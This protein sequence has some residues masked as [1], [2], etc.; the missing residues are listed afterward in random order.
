MALLGPERIGS[1]S[2]G[3]RS[4]SLFSSGTEVDIKG[5]SKVCVEFLF[6]EWMF[7]SP[8]GKTKVN[9]LSNAL[10]KIMFIL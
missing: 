2:S 5:V 1:F 6:G 9:Q 10:V 7:S 3:A 4:S 8:G